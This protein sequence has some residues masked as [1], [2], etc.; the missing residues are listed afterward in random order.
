MMTDNFDRKNIFYRIL[1]NHGYGTVP[2]YLWSARDREEALQI[3]EE[4]KAALGEKHVKL[5]FYGEGEDKQWIL[6]AFG[7]CGGQLTGLTIYK[8]E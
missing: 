2:H 3:V 7:P 4:M 8:G 6:G 1:A 5:W